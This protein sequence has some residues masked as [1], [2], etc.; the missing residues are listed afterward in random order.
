MFCSVFCILYLMILME[1][2]ALPNLSGMFRFSPRLI[3]YLRLF[4]IVYFVFN[5]FV[6][7]YCFTFSSRF[8][9]ASMIIEQSPAALQL[10][11]LQTLNSISSGWITILHHN[12]CNCLTF[13]HCA[14]RNILKPSTPYP[15][16]KKM[17]SI[18]RLP[19]SKTA[20]SFKDDI[21]SKDHHFYHHHADRQ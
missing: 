2:C 10:R 7:K 20:S 3:F 17:K 16:V 5:D 14:Y 12:S 11:Y 8:R 19:S 9:E 21:I 18:L 4:C 1:R 6:F 15:Q 13:L